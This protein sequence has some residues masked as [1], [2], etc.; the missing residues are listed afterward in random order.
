MMTISRSSS[1][2]L[3]CHSY[4]VTTFIGSCFC[5][6]DLL[7]ISICQW[8]HLSCSS[9]LYSNLQEHDIQRTHVWFL[10]NPLVYLPLPYFPEKTAQCQQSSITVGQLLGLLV[11]WSCLL[12][13]PG[14]VSAAA[15]LGVQR[16][17]LWAILEVWIAPTLYVSPPVLPHK[18]FLVF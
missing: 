16:E 3:E 6:F 17:Y 1:L 9:K 14:S 11:P 8:K 13:T 12:M 7:S 5:S 15:F 18:C 4:S 10:E 2:V